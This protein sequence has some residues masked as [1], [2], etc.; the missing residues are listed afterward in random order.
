MTS[1]LLIDSFRSA[2][3][4]ITICDTST[5]VCVAVLV[6]AGRLTS[7]PRCDSGRAAMKITSS[8]S[9]TSII[10][11]MFMSDDD[12][13]LLRLDDAVRAVVHVGVGH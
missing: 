10:G 1:D 8:T 12:F 5:W 4:S 6:S 3:Y 13:E 2:V 11:V 7:R 9:S